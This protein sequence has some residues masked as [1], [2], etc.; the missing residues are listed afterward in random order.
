MSASSAASVEPGPDAAGEHQAV[1]VLPPDE[2]RT[3]RRRTVALAVG[4]SADHH[5]DASAV[6]DLHQF[7][8]ALA[9]P[10]RCFRGAWPSRL[11]GPAHRSP[12][13]RSAPLADPVAR[14]DPVR[15]RSRR[16]GRA[17][18]DG[19]RS[20]S[21]IVSCSPTCSTSKMY[22]R[23]LALVPLQHP[24][25]GSPSS[26]S[27]TSSPSRIAFGAGRPS[28]VQPA[29]GRSSVTSRRAGD[30]RRTRRRRQRERAI[31]VALDLVRPVVVVGGQPPEHRLHRL[32][33]ERGS[34]HRSATGGAPRARRIR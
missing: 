4:V 18:A 28:A 11:R 27:T 19:P 31:A 21:S 12:P 1:A 6:L 13:A 3:E 29:R 14:H 17:G 5:V 25:R 24:K 16:A 20:G 26:S 34:R 30:C 7:G 15:S 22:E 9:E 8:R 33:R 2:Q 23:G 32:D 10:D